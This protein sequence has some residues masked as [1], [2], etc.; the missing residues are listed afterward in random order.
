[1]QTHTPEQT[2]S[3]SVHSRSRASVFAF[4]RSEA[5]LA[6]RHP[7]MLLA[8]VVS[9]WLALAGARDGAPIWQ[10]L[11]VDAAGW[12]LPLTVGAYL[13]GSNSSSSEWHQQTEEFLDSLANGRVTRTLG[14]VLA[15]VAPVAY[16][17][18]VALLP[19]LIGFGSNPAGDII[20]T[21]FA[22]V[23]LSVALA[24]TVGCLV[25]SLRWFRPAPSLFLVVYLFLQLLASPDIEIGASGPSQSDAGRLLL[26]LPASAFESPFEL[27]L[28]PSTQR[29]FY[30]VA[31]LVA[32]VLLL[33]WRADR[34]TSGR[35]WLLPSMLAATG[36]VLGLAYIAMSAIPTAEWA[37]Q[38][39]DR[40][41]A[42][43]SVL[44][45]EQQCANTEGVEYCAYPTFEPWID[46]WSAAI[47]ESVRLA[48][49]RVKGVVQ[50]PSNTAFDGMDPG[51][52]WLTTGFSW[53]YP[54]T[55]EPVHAFALAAA[56]GNLVVGLP[57]GYEESCDAQA[58]G[59]SVLPLWL[60]A[61]SVNQGETLL[62]RLAEAPGAKASIG[63]VGLGNATIGSDAAFVAVKLS[64]LSDSNV[65]EVLMSRYT[66]LVD[67][68][69]T[70]GD[71]A[72]WFGIADQG[73][74][75]SGSEIN[76]PVCG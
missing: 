11:S 25:G 27:M 15:G 28:R 36:A 63:G 49:T 34:P 75:E 70:V 38:S 20:W 6:A 53:D 8:V 33:M 5:V 60:A 16:S 31:A 37:A 72:A 30:L 64:E 71:V 19:I 43:W 7:L 13:L 32:I 14:R 10:M 48:P 39:L 74:A 45:S 26:W 42:D 66:E 1:M 59:R 69:T 23:P 73:A 2:S 65:E 46:D 9:L 55:S 58:Q 61:T 50:R 76:L 3:T 24:W 47:A 4:A 18:I 17:I 57:A 22:I 29:F 12:M 68:R 62:Q 51:P 41:R 35:R 56:A 67:P 40:P 52:G 54:R 21:E 44:T